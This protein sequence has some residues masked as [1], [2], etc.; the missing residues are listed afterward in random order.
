MNL[1]STWRI[2]KNHQKGKFGFKPK[3]R[4]FAE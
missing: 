3:V 4:K 1:R 2:Q